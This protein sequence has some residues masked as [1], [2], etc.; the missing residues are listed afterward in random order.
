MEKEKDF[1]GNLDKVLEEAAQKAIAE[2]YAA[3]R[4]S[5]H[6]DSKGIY[7]LYPDGKKEYIKLYGDDE[8]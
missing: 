4:A 6:G 7:H 8:R 5:T 2:T 3:G 1:W